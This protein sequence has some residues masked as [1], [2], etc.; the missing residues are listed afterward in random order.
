MRSLC[1]AQQQYRLFTAWY[2]AKEI[3]QPTAFWWFHHGLLYKQ[4]S[5]QLKSQR[6]FS[7]DVQNY[8]WVQT[9]LLSTPSHSSR[10]PGLLELQ[11]LSPQHRAAAELCLGFCSLCCSLE[12]TSGRILVIHSTHLIFPFS[13]EYSLLSVFKN[14]GWF[15]SFVEKTIPTAVDPLRPKVEYSSF[16]FFLNYALVA[17]EISNFTGFIKQD[18]QKAFLFL[19]IFH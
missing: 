10:I 19:N 12:T 7:A 15:C 8:F 16:F 14:L 5:T 1:Y 2:K 11:L 9:I 18:R 6:N 13:R 3:V 4:S 17:F